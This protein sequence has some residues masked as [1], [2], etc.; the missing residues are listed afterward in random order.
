MIHYPDLT[1]KQNILFM[2]L[3]SI[4]F[5]LQIYIKPHEVLFFSLGWCEYDIK[6]TVHYQ[7]QITEVGACS[8][9][10]DIATI[11]AASCRVTPIT[12]PSN[13]YWVLYGY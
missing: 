10:N 7:D 3:K 11:T 2:P 4:I 13:D 1:P 12:G 6:S 9:G 5:I 8:G